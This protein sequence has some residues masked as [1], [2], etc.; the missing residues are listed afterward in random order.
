V[1]AEDRAIASRSKWN[2]ETP[3]VKI[4]R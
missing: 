4:V 3:D 2:T 1:L